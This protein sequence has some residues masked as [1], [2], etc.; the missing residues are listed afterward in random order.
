MPVRVLRDN[1]LHPGG[2]DFL[3]DGRVAQI[4]VELVEQI[5]AITV[6]G[7]VRTVAE[8]LGL[9]VLREVIGHEQRAAGERLEDA[10]GR[11]AA[12]AVGV[13]AAWHVQ[14]Q[15]AAA[16][17]FGRAQIGNVAAILDAGVGE[18]AAAGEGDRRQEQQRGDESGS[19]V[20]SS[21][22]RE[23]RTGIREGAFSRHP[24]GL[25]NEAAPVY[26]SQ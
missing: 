17:S 16:V 1:F 21:S 18:L 15:A 2:L 14:G 13:L 24:R 7:Q 19:H 23:V 20:V 11:N 26:S 22:S 9:A 8:Q 3:A 10:N 6:G 12:E 4:V 5:V 25:T